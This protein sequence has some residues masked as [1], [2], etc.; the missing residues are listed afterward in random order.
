MNDNKYVSLKQDRCHWQ[1]LWEVQRLRAVR[2]AYAAGAKIAVVTAFRANLRI[3][4]GSMAVTL[5]CDRKAANV[6]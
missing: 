4:I 6:A 3:G 1:Q 5:N 2:V